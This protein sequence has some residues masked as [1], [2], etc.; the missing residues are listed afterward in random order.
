MKGEMKNTDF[1]ESYSN[2]QL[3]DLICYME[4]KK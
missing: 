1:L 3:D 2:G 4:K